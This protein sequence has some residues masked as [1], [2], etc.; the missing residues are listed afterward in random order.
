MN[1][2]KTILYSSRVTYLLSF[3]LTPF[4]FEIFAP[5]K[6]ILLEESFRLHDYNARLIKD[7]GGFYHEF[8]NHDPSLSWFRQNKIYLF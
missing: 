7:K 3:D 4:S 6:P 5:S 8:D 2:T 1:A